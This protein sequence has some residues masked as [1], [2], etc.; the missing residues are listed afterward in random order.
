MR[1]SGLGRRIDPGQS[2]CLFRYSSTF[3]LWLLLPSPVTILEGQGVMEQ[4]QTI[5]LTWKKALLIMTLCVGA[6][7]DRVGHTYH[8]KGHLDSADLL[9]AGMSI[10]T[11]FCA[12]AFVGWWANREE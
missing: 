6:V 11:A 12:V 3:A 7:S 5:K 9:V 8:Q 2:S 10:A 1:F 4:K